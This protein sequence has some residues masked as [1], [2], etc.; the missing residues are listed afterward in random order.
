[1]AARQLMPVGVEAAF[2][3]K[4]APARGALSRRP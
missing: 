4:I 3:E 1:M 2:L